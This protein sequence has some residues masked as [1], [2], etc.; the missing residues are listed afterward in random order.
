MSEAI[1]PVDFDRDTGYFFQAAREGRLVY[2]VC[3]SCGSGIHLPT[4]FCGRCGGN[5][6]EWRQASGNGTLFSWTTVTQGVHPAY[7]APYT[8]VVV[9]LDEAPEVRLIGSLP[10]A[11]GLRAGQAMRVCFDERTRETGLPQWR[12]VSASAPT[13][14]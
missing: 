2:R 11:V 4:Q 13:A 14:S 10:G 6:T 9:A 8:I 1:E 5:D 3:R 7:P 12:P